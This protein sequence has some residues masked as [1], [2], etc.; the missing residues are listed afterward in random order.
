MNAELRMIRALRAE[1]ELLNR[2]LAET[3]AR[4]ARVEN[5]A[6]GQPPAPR[7]DGPKP[8]GRGGVA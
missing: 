2:A 7:P 6:I 5:F 1:V 3:E 4:I 8:D